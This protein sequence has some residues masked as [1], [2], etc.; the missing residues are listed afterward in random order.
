MKKALNVLWGLIAKFVL[1]GF[2]YVFMPYLLALLMHALIP[3]IEVL[4]GFIAAIVGVTAWGLSHG[5]DKIAT[6][7]TMLV[8]LKAGEKK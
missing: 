2:E 7:V 4:W 3:N 8:V 5:I 1:I 6:S